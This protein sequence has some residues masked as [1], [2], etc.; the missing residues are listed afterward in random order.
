MNSKI[1]FQDNLLKESKRSGEDRLARTGKEY[2]VSTMFTYYDLNGDD[3]LDR[4][5]L[6]KVREQFV[7]VC[8]LHF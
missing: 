8:S 2:M 1:L 4:E 6:H 7:A 3:H 5:E